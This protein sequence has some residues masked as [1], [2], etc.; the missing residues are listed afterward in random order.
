MS[1]QVVILAGGM[2]TR[3]QSV[4]GNLPKAMIPVAGRPFIL[5]QLDLLKRSGIDQVLLLVG[6]RGDMISDLLGDGSQ[7]GFSIEYV[8]EKP[9]ALLGTGGALVNAV[10]KLMPE[11]L[12]MYGDSYLPVDYRAMIEWYHNQQRPSV[13]SV[14]RNHGQ[15]DASNVRIDGDYVVYY[16][17]KA[18]PGSAD[19][20][21]YGLS[22]FQ[23]NIIASYRNHP[24]PLDLAVI[25]SDL[26]RAG[27]LAAY[28]VHDRFYEI[29]KPSGLAELDALLK[30]SSGS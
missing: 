11:F 7:L 29:G 2:G 9:D 3:I 30:E 23:R 8:H 18:P 17:K 27:Q 14:Y 5:H 24:M 13:M 19:F 25:Q 4:A 20:I 12:L 26:V 10:D 16:D 6:Y 1:M 21:D 15:W 22:I 28:E